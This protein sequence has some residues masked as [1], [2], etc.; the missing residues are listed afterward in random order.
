M[1]S[2]YNEILT[3]ADVEKCV[4]AKDGRLQVLSDGTVRILKCEAFPA[5][6]I[7]GRGASSSFIADQL[8]P[9]V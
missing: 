7:Y 6:A 1:S 8:V 4:G 5:C 9:E 2:H 3:I